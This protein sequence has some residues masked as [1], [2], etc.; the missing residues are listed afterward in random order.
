MRGTAI[1]TRDFAI[2]FI[3]GFLPRCILVLGIPYYMFLRYLKYL[4]AKEAA[5]SEQ[6]ASSV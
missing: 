5:R 3:A 4:D 1:S 6:I 2:L